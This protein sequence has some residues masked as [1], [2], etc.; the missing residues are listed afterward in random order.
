MINPIKLNG[1]WDEGYA[2]DRHIVSSDFLGVDESGYNRFSTK[3]TELGEL[4]YQM[5]Y[6]G[7]HN[8]S[9]QILS[10][11]KKFLDIWLKNKN[12]HTIIPIPPSI[13]DRDSQPVFLIAEAIA[14]HYGIDC[15]KDILFKTSNM[16]SK[17]MQRSNKELRGTIEQ[18]KQ[19]RCPCNIL[20]ID[21]VYSTGATASECVRVLRNDNFIDKIYLLVV[22]KTKP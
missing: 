20:L 14:Q 19:A 15:R 4:M 6:N 18:T 11:S 17:E 22:T 8:T 1:N 2:L 10:L 12:I 16:Q 3:R 13:K 21:D 9:Q 5:K 7:H